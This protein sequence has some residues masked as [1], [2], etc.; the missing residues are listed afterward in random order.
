MNWEQFKNLKTKINQYEES[1]KNTESELIRLHNHKYAVLLNNYRRIFV[2]GHISYNGVDIADML[3]D[4]CGDLI[5]YEH[6]DNAVIVFEDI[7]TTRSWGDCRCD[8]LY[9]EISLQ[10]LFD[11][12]KLTDNIASVQKQIQEHKSS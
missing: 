10:D 8:S 12:N 3:F 1:K 5:L 9:I 6:K 4:N 11:K 2:E 7:G